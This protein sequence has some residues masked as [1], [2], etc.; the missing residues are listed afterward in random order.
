MAIWD[1]PS[2]IPF[3]DKFK[4]KVGVKCSAECNL[5]DKK[6]GI[7]DQESH[8][9]A[10]GTLGDVPWLATTTLYFAEV[11]L[12]APGTE[13]CYRWEARFPKPDLELPHEQAAYT[14]AFATAK[15]PEHVVTVEV[16][17]KRTKA[18]IENADVLLQAHGG[19][20]Y[21]CYTDQ[22]GVTKLEVA[23]GDYKLYV[24]AH[25]KEALQTTVE[26]A[27]DVTIKAELPEEEYWY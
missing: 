2:P 6:I 17:D 15:Q 7:Y 21:R 16:I 20:P 9:V 5:M 1:V 25:H 23:K 8:K 10:T 24:S 22:R 13:G 3:N 18:P 12:K 4:L 19:Y 11:E 27:S 26:V 14:F